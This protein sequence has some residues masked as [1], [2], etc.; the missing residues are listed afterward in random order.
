MKA[1]QQNG[2]KTK[3]MNVFGR[4]YTSEKLDD[5]NSCFCATCYLYS[6]AINVALIFGAIRVIMH[7]KSGIE[8]AEFGAV[9]KFHQSTSGL[10]LVRYNF[11]AVLL[12]I[13]KTLIENLLWLYVFF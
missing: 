2:M 9:V 5:K 12:L 3:M 1:S 8:E 7:Q 4:R 6:C 11:F 10:P 13:T